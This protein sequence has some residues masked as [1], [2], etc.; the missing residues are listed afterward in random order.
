LVTPDW[1]WELTTNP[2]DDD[3]VVVELSGRLPIV[4]AAVAGVSAIELG[5]YPG[6]D[7]VTV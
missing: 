6:A 1:T 7:A 4:V 5:A 3:I 2:P